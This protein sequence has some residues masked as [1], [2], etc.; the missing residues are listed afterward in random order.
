MLT[1]KVKITEVEVK[2]ALNEVWLARL[3]K[4]VNY[5]VNYARA[6]ILM[7]GKELKTQCLYVLN[8]IQYWRGETAKEVRGIL[9]RFVGGK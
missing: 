2:K 6:G 1:A 5:A 4:N 7:S 3:D 9:K 8:N